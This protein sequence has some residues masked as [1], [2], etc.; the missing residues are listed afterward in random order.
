MDMNSQ[1]HV[2]AALPPRK[3]PPVPIG[4]K[5]GC[6]P[7]CVWTLWRTKKIPS[8]KSNPGRSARSLITVPTELPT[9]A[10]IR[11]R[12]I[13]DLKVTVSLLCLTLHLVLHEMFNDVENE[14]KTSLLRKYMKY[15]IRINKQYS[16]GVLHVGVHAFRM[17]YF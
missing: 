16:K 15:C 8:P 5:S 14:K 6:A 11:G 9:Q 3:N 17:C 1:L 10:L 7:G 4:Q 2:P 12:C 13:R